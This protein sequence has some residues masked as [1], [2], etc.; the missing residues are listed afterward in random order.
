M[1]FHWFHLLSR[2]SRAVS[3]EVQEEI[4]ALAAA[5]RVQVAGGHNVLGIGL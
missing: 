4:A 2:P 5:G 1:F 3:E